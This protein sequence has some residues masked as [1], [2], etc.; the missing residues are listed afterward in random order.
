M[1]VT[2]LKIK[3]RATRQGST[4]LNEALRLDNISLKVILGVEL[5]LKT[6]LYLKTELEMFANL[7]NL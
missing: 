2:L 5:D 1:E 6:L 3:E 7:K 4:Y